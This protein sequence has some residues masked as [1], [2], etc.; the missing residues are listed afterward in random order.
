MQAATIRQISACFMIV[1]SFLLSSSKESGLTLGQDQPGGS[2]QPI[3]IPDEPKSIDAT[4]LVSPRLAE[5]VTVKFDGKPLKDVFVWLQGKRALNLQVDYRALATAKILD[6]EPVYEELNNVP[7]YLLLDRLEMIGLGWYD[8]DDSL[9]ITSREESIKHLTSVAFHLGD[10]LDE[11]Y[12]VQELAGMITKCSGGAW[13]HTDNSVDGSAD[14]LGDVVFI[15][16]TARVHREIAGL[17]A[18]LRNHGRRTFSLDSPGNAVLRTS[19]DQKF[20]VDFK[21]TPLVTAVTELA[22]RSSID[23]RLDR[24][25][26]ARV[27]TR[28]RIPMTLRLD[29]QKLG[30]VIR[31]LTAN[32]ALA[33]GL[34]DEVLWIGADAQSNRFHKTAV[35]D[36][37]DLCRDR[38]E[39][40]A[41]KQT[42]QKQIRSRGQQITGQADAIE[43]PRPGTLVVRGSEPTLDFI[44]ESL[45]KYRAALRVSKL[46]IPAGIDPTELT[47]GYYRLPTRMANDTSS[48]IRSTVSPDSWSSDRNPTAV[49]SIL[50]LS[51][52][53]TVFDTKSGP[54][55]VENSVLVIRQTRLAHREI[56]R[57]I[58]ALVDSK[59]VDANAALPPA[60]DDTQP[61]GR[62]G[63][64]LIPNGAGANGEGK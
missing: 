25:S 53:P 50:L 33:W 47:V 56:G 54:H 3:V 27:N 11:G 59:T 7:L 20:S 57:Q 14:F 62:F 22:R 36:V 48:M 60:K 15:T 10:L 63:S 49:G 13:G 46:R 43:L 5:L 32:H 40:D 18:A 4:K 34:R 9:V 30:V 51:S 24:A 39:S 23:L 41:L 45:E 31:A 2:K 16:Q 44:L 21:E 42:L 19:L 35:Y 12:S 28:E 8:Q 38:R 29:D 58:Q 17:L 6:T 37:R 64:G 1:G 55:V 26:L 52:E 61:L